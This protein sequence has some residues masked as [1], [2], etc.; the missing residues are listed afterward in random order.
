MQ[1]FT[2]LGRN[3]LC[4]IFLVCSFSVWAQNQENGQ[5][6]GAD[7]VQQEPAQKRSGL[8]ATGTVRHATTGEPLPGINISIPEYSAAL[9]DEK[10]NFAIEVPSYE[11]TLLLSGQTIQNKQV[12]LKGRQDVQVALHEDAFSSVYE[13]ALLPSGSLARNQ[14][15]YSVATLNMSGNWAQPFET[16]DNF[17][18][19][20]VSGV[21]V[22]RRSGTPGQG[23]EMLIRGFS[24]LNASN[25][26]LIVVDGMVYDDYS[27]GK[28]ILS[29]HINNPLSNID[30]KDID[31]ITVIKDGASL[32]G[33]KGANGVILITTAHAKELATKIDFAAYGG[34][35]FAPK[36]LPVMDSRNFRLYLADIL[37][38]SG[39]TDAQIE[40]QPYMNDDPANPEYAR[41][42]SNTNWQDKVLANS[43]SQN[44]YMKVTG[45][46][47]IAK[48]ALSVG[49]LENKG[50]VR[51]TSQQRYST[52]FN[53]DLNLTPRLKAVTSLSFTLN[54][55]DL[56]NQGLDFVT[57][58][59]LAGLVKAP[60]LRVQQVTPEGIESPNLAD[61]DV[62]NRSNPVALIN[63][64]QA[65]DQS[66]RFFGSAKFMYALTKYSSVNSLIGLTFD[67]VRENL[68]IPR[69]G[70]ASEV[71]D[72]AIA[73]SRL[74]NRVQRYY[75]LYNDSYYAYNR[76]WAGGHS[77]TGNV[78]FRYSNIRSEED[79]TYGFNSPTD[80]FTTVGTGESSLRAF[81]G[82]IGEA[83]WLNTYL[84]ADYSWLSK[85]QLSF[86]LS[87][88][89]SSR[90]GRQISNAPAIGGNRLAVLPSVAAAWVLS[91]ERFM[92]G[93]SNVDLL[94]V[95]LSYGLTGNDDIGNYTGRQYY[96]SRNLLGAQGTI[97]GNLANPAI[98]WET[99]TK[100]NLGVETALF[101]ERLSVSVDVFQNKTTDM[102]VYEPVL[103]ASGFDY[104]LT[105]N[106]GM[107][108]R[109]VDVS[110]FSRVLDKA[111]KLDL[112]LTLSSYRNEITRLPNDRL[113]TDFAGATILT[114]VGRPASQFYG[115]KTNGIYATQADAAN[116]NLSTRLSDGSLV[117]FQAGDV[118]FVDLNNDNIID[119]QDR[120][121]IGDANPDFFGSLSG[122]LSWKR[123]SLSALFTFRSGNDIYNAVRA[124][125]ESGSTTQN[126]LAS[127]MNR[128]QF[129]GQ[130]TSMPRANF[131]DPLGNNRFSDRWIE[132]GSYLRLRTISVSYA[133]PVKPGFVKNASVYATANN[134]FTSSSYLGYDPEFSA[135]GGPIAQGIDVGMEPLYKSILFG[136]RVGL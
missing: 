1:I 58:P 63:N 81:T 118:R 56:S 51:E 98:K 121:I 39:M 33:T 73:F 46:D 10:G 124:N 47:N 28:S 101:N 59:I 135:A 60:F 42:L 26:P 48:Y 126:Q 93:L 38:S 66:Y 130:N 6:T 88:D 136:V 65:Q 83:I 76:S 120:T 122:N 103:P 57:N 69:L 40:A 67:K 109:G 15:P 119:Q 104:V 5:E 20:R 117:P 11:A 2:Q 108:T 116:A 30:I 32:Y 105:N 61:T 3:S 97:R 18:Q 14:I 107:K 106:G 77:L 16:A 114:E 125:L 70:V 84:S 133:L 53:A 7:Q 62:F 71:L 82:D 96:V 78:G 99:N 43:T 85:Y 80:D 90:F 54:E 52:R 35:N 128:W 89:G 87:V 29:Q 41:Y 131:G 45:G 31:N 134:L 8:K 113:L 36:N 127:V 111:F 112:G 91:S 25:R 86:N 21:D 4:L 95:R 68:F 13:T 79:R 19:G 94:K 92:A 37:K 50:I 110:A 55:Q 27:Y 9:T 100:L 123:F 17:L 74:G 132:D 72:N 102:L 44:Y 115:Y 34:V 49:Y 24:S 75:S 23:A 129:E 64:V 12:A 22:T